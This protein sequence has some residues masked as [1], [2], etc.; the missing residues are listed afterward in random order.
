MTATLHSGRTLRADP[1]STVHTLL[2]DNYDSYTYNLFQLLAVVNGAEPT[3]IV[4]DGDRWDSLDLSEFD[5]VVISP[6]PGRPEGRDFG[7]NPEL[8]DATDLPVLGVCL[9][10]QGLA[11]HFGAQV[12]SAPEPLHGHVATVRHTGTGVFAGVPQDFR[13]VRYH[14]LCVAEP[15]PPQLEAHAWS[16]D[17]VLMG[18]KVRDRD[19]WG[20]Q[21]HP[22]SI[23]TEHGLALLANFRDITVDVRATTRPEPGRPRVTVPA[24]PAPATPARLHRRIRTLAGQFDTEAAFAELFGDREYAAW[25]DS[26]RVEP[27][28]S[29]YSIL[30]APAGS[31]GEVITYSVA[32]GQAR[33]MSGA[34]ATA[35]P[36]VAGGDI[37][38]VLNRRL[39]ERH[40]PASELPFAGGY[41]GY[42]G[43]EL[44]ADCGARA[45]HT[46]ATPD[47][48]WMF[49]DRLIVVD[50]ETDRTHLV[51]VGERSDPALDAWLEETETAV[52][53]LAPVDVPAAPVPTT[54]PALAFD[55]ARYLSDI[56]ECQRLLRAGESYEVCLTDTAHLPSTDDPLAFYLRQ[57]RANPAPYASFLRLGETSVASSSPERF[58]KVTADRMV[59]T[60]PI[61]GTAARDGDPRCD[62][63]LA[64]TLADSAKTR[65]ENLMIVDL[66]RND[67]GR[68]CVPGSVH[69]PHFMAVETYATVHQLVST[70]RGSLRPGIST[71]DCVRACFPGGSMTGAPKLRTMEILDRLETEA[72]GIYSGAIGW[73]SPDG[74]ADLSVVIRSATLTSQE[75]TVG[76][77]GAIVLASDPADEYQEM[78]LKVRA[79]LSGERP[80]IARA[81][82]AADERCR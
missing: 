29:R 34:G 62:E 51:A 18:L 80:G 78:L 17:G 66:L 8:L 72:R 75:T 50:H 53:R 56:N 57:R 58:L 81:P 79:T 64:S 11:A 31:S 65:A 47:A 14:S 55:R 52:G 54:D 42:F 63:R 68:V 45:S 61:K 38:D 16:E 46:A 9:G 71:M 82:S 40:L 36:D 25:L 74:Q 59:E 27:G 21:F 33:I 67:L 35:D 60:K 28:L 3:V 77:G 19:W 6:G 1:V 20:V 10:H 24:R 44:K 39:S 73:L 43:Y 76:A 41:V 26:S 2:V 7:R 15:L 13:A 48:V 37:F 4:N 49:L 12:R 70:I 30:G 32:D 22:E 69:V 5:N 23:E